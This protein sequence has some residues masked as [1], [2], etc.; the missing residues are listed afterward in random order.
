MAKYHYIDYIEPNGFRFRSLSQTHP[1]HTGFVVDRT[2]HKP[3][4]R[5]AQL[6]APAPP[7]PPPAPAPPAPP[8]P[9]PAPAPPAPPPPPPAPAPPTIIADP[10][11]QFQPPPD[12]EDPVVRPPAPPPPP[13]AP[14]PPTIIADPVD[15][16][17]PRPV[18]EEPVERPPAPPPPRPAPGDV[19][20]R[21]GV[22]ASELAPGLGLVT[23]NATGQQRVVITN[24]EAYETSLEEPDDEPIEL[25]EGDYLSAADVA[26]GNFILPPGATLVRDDA[27]NY[28][29]RRSAQA[30]E[31]REIT[32]GTGDQARTVS[33]TS[34]EAATLQRL[35]AAASA[36]EAEIAHMLATDWGPEAWARQEEL[37][38][39][40]DALAEHERSLRRRG[41]RREADK[42]DRRDAANR[43]ARTPEQQAAHDQA[44]ADLEHFRAT[45]E[46]AEQRQAR[47]TAATSTRTPDEA[48]PPL[49]AQ[50]SEPLPAGS[51]FFEQ[52]TV[53]DGSLGTVDQ[54][55]ANAEAQA[56][57]P[58]PSPPP[59]AAYIMPEGEYSVGTQTSGGASAQFRHG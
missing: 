44:L 58:S 9:P 54:D 15:Q 21:G 35:R 10:V 29:V 14:A 30:E 39:A 43:E 20:E 22:N 37:Q 7:P 8:P 4:Y 36:A 3:A 48:E 5:P 28:V 42:L 51:G 34:S 40:I 45:G 6:P 23:D 56:N 27:G 11:D 59:V 38:P 13:P 55:I 16:F 31:G 52:D 49:S 19:F 12:P 2:V 46:T 1:D 18:P 47:E 41:R 50:P 32:V 24:R 26:A 53:L 57:Q 33:L 17:Q 25:E